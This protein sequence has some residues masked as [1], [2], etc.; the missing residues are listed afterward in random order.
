[1][2][3]GAG[4]GVPVSGRSSDASEEEDE[5]EEGEGL[6]ELQAAVEA[7]VAPVA[8]TVARMAAAS[9]A[10][11]HRRRVVGSPVRPPRE[12]AD[13][14]AGQ[15]ALPSAESTPRS[16]ATLDQMFSS[17]QEDMLLSTDHAA[18][19]PGS[20]PGWDARR[21]SPRR[22]L[23]AAA[24]A[25]ADAER[26][27]AASTPPPA[28]GAPPSPPPSPP[29]S[30]SRRAPGAT[31]TPPLPAARPSSAGSR[32]STVSALRGRKRHSMISSPE[33]DVAERRYSGK[34][35]SVRSPP[36]SVAGSSQESFDAKLKKSAPT[37]VLPGEVALN[38][39]KVDFSN[40]M[41]GNLM[42]AG[43]GASPALQPSPS[44]LV[45]PRKS[46]YSEDARLGARSRYSGSRPGSGPGSASGRA[47]VVEFGGCKAP[48]AGSNSNPLSRRAAS[49]PLTV[50]W[51]EAASSEAPDGEAA[52]SG[53][54]ESAGAHRSPHVGGLVPQQQRQ[55]VTKVALATHPALL[56][57][58]TTLVFGPYDWLTFDD[59]EA[60]NVAAA[61]DTDALLTFVTL[62]ELWESS[63]GL[64][65]QS[66]LYVRYL[67]ATPLTALLYLLSRYSAARQRRDT[68]EG[69]LRGGAGR[70]DH[71]RSHP[72]VGKPT[73]RGRR[74]RRQY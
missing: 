33:H 23:A 22:S 48:S 56:L 35:L 57:L 26:R 30:K 11:E 41:A 27:L 69:T 70:G 18:A 5:E 10:S 25:R 7:G 16:A 58:V 68:P 1:V 71:A 42:V 55:S 72:R 46:R 44:P 31:S 34:S 61:A 45:S 29:P 3:A 4:G 74:R 21:P 43:G 32:H 20:S 13:G 47:E 63:W 2:R 6:E 9:A 15:S 24:A 60:P 39:Q 28:Q 38:P 65:W 51:R 8:T 14:S 40:I 49:P 73:R 59:V 62:E 67:I 66:L 12:S 19:S 37:A 50:G 52:G 17:M 64:S 36:V 53:A 54:A